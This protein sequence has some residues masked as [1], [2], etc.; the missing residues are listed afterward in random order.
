MF[1]CWRE[2]RRCRSLVGRCPVG[3]L[4]SP[5]RV[6]PMAARVCAS[7]WFMALRLLSSRRCRHCLAGFEP[8]MRRS[9][10]SATSR[11][12]PGMSDGFHAKASRLARRKSMSSHSY[13]VGCWVPICTLL[14]GSVGSIPTALVSSS[15][16]KAVEE[17]GL[18]Q[19]RTARVDNSPSRGSSEELMM[20][21]AS[22]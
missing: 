14:V 1:K 22:S 15:G 2:R 17:V 7:P 13:L 8:R 12:M 4:R 21:V 9:A 16:R 18:L 11:G 3:S 20:A 19:S 5:Y 6:L 10:C